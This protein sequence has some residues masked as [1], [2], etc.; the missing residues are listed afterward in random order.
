VL[1]TAADAGAT[2]DAL[3]DEPGSTFWPGV[4]PR[5]SH[6]E[7]ARRAQAIDDPDR[8]ADIFTRILLVEGPAATGAPA[9]A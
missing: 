7:A 4:Q 2:A 8:A 1:S 9:G 6:G 3:A 5:A